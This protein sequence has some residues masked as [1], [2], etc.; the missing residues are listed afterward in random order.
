METVHAPTNPLLAD[1]DGDG[2][3]DLSEINQGR[4]PNFAELT[5]WT[6]VGD[7]VWARQSSDLTVFQSFNSTSHAFYLSPY[8]L[9]NKK[10][11][12]EMKVSD[13]TDNDISDS[14]WAR[15][16][17]QLSLFLLGPVPSLEEQ[18]PPDGWKFQRVEN[19]VTT[20]LA[21]D[22]TDYTM[23][24]EQDAQYKV[25]VHYTSGKTVIHLQGGTLAYANGQTLVSASGNFASGKFAFY[26][27]SQPSIT[28]ENLKFEPLYSPTLS[29]IGNSSMTVEGAT[30]FSDPGAT[31]SDPEDG[32]LTSTLL[33]GVRYCRSP[34]RRPIC[35]D[36]FGHRFLRDRGERHPRW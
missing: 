28:Y 19:G 34:N 11:T 36:L 32:N 3:D 1:S 23:G 8:D 5:G 29:L 9:L 13:A 26:C 33:Q 10:I 27:N 12:F 22:E 16:C 25:T 31:A 14:S 17:F 4:N 15:G 21:V 6:E 7:A 18:T 30:S 35:F 2:V 24:W 20:V